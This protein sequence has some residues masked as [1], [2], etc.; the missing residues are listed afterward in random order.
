MLFSYEK[1]KIFFFVENTKE[2]RVN[3][4]GEKE[5]DC[6]GEAVGLSSEVPSLVGLDWLFEHTDS[7]TENKPSSRKLSRAQ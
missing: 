6:E 2:N 3:E 1:L 7:E 4:D 5:Q